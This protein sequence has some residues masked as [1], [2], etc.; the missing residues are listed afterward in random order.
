MVEPLKFVMGDSIHRLLL[1]LPLV[2]LYGVGVVGAVVI[3]SVAL[4]KVVGCL[5]ILVLVVLNEL[6]RE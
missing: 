3:A 1:L 2:F 4:V 6:S 5:V